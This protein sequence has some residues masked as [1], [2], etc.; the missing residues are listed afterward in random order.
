MAD[1]HKPDQPK[2]LEMRVAELEDKLSK[3]HITEDEM[4][5]YQKV[6]SLMGSQ[7]ATQIPQLCVVNRCITYR[8]LI[9]TV[10]ACIYECSCGPCIAGG[11]T[12]GAG[13]GFGSLG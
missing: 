9:H 4:K 3:V 8:C 12:G 1:Q 7:A 5:T 11:G 13:G 2:T 10:C 6:A